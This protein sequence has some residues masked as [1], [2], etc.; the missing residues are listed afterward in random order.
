MADLSVFQRIRSKED[1]DRERAEFDLRKQLAQAQIVKAQK[2][3]YMP[4]V[5]K[6]GEVA[7]WKAAQGVELTPQEQAAAQFLDAKSGGIMFDPATGAVTQ[8]PRLSQR[9]NIGGGNTGTPTMG[10]GQPMPQYAPAEQ[11]TEDMS[12]S[13]PDAPQIPESRGENAG[14]QNPWD[15]EYKRQLAEAGGNP[16]LIQN[17]KEAYAK[18]KLSMSDTEAKNALYADRMILSEPILTD[19]QKIKASTNWW[20]LTKDAVNPFGSNIFNSEDYK[21]YKQ[22]KLDAASARLRQESGAVIA[23]SEYANDAKQLYPQ[24]NEGPEVIAQK[25]RNREAI[26][27]GLMRAAGPAYQPPNPVKPSTGPKSVKKIIVTNPKTGEQRLIPDSLYGEA[28]KDG[29]E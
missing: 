9:I 7:F 3:A 10:M 18:S 11:M 26:R 24:L 1:F 5:D 17:V 20:E 22:A 23:D 29:W 6:L 12:Y 16:K 25:A 21:S 13:M 19:P 28:R 8:K 15:V 14:Y 4:D 2:D 27:N